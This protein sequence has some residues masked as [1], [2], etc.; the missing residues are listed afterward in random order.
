MKDLISQVNTRKLKVQ[1]KTVRYSS[2]STYNKCARHYDFVYN[3]G[4]TVRDSAATFKGTIVHTQLERYY[5]EEIN[6]VKDNFFYAVEAKLAEAGMPYT[7]L[8]KQYAEEVNQVHLRATA[9]YSGS[10]AIRTAKGTVPSDP[11]RTTGWKEAMAQLE[12]LKMTIDSTYS[13][14]SFDPCEAIA[15]AWSLLSSYTYPISGKVLALEL[16]ISYWDEENSKLINP[17]KLP[18]PID[19]YLKGTADM[20]IEIEGEVWVIDHKTSKQEYTPY[21]VG[22]NPQLSL[23]AYAVEKLLKRPVAG[24]GINSIR[25]KTLVLSPRLN[26]EAVFEAALSQ[27]KGIK[28]DSYP[29]Q[30]P[31]GPYSPCLRWFGGQCPFLHECWGECPG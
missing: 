7:P 14:L 29:Q 6:S 19:M 16:P 31:E 30:I 21:N 25:Q 9:D 27:V 26:K 5:K 28:N 24:V 13:L 1:P 4:R 2:L 3:Q 8:L 12:P 23:Y 22:H 11:K 20:V 10:D 15:E 17:I 18:K